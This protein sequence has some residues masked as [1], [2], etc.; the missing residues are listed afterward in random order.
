MVKL[1]PN[2][3]FE[4]VNEKGILENNDGFFSCFK[5]LSV[6]LGGIAMPCWL[7]SLYMMLISS[8]PNEQPTTDQAEVNT[9]FETTTNTCACF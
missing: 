5:Q 3:L 7:A 4:T 2:G 9:Y 8:V 6:L 1:L